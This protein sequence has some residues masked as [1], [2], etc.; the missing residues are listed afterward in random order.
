[1]KAEEIADVLVNAHR[2]GF[3]IQ[4]WSRQARVLAAAVKVFEVE[5]AE[6]EMPT[7]G[8]EPSRAKTPHGLLGSRVKKP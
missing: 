6:V 5:R 2:G 3:E 8:W 1:M 4:H 7:P